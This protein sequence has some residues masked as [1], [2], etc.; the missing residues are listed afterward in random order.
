MSRSKGDLGS[1]QYYTASTTN[2]QGED[3]TSPS[4]YLSA[5]PSSNP[6][7]H[8]WTSVYLKYCDGASFSGRKEVGVL[9][10]T[11]GGHDQPHTIETAATTTTATVNINNIKTIATTNTN[12]MTNT[13]TTTHHQDTSATGLYYR[14][15]YALDALLADL[16]ANQVN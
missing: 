8:T 11:I 6:L 4:G 13:N 10:S 5:D 9:L 2:P 7:M 14:G 12:T 15:G 3:G 16:D 1:S